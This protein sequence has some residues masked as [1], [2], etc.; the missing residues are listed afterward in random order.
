VTQA[1]GTTPTSATTQEA[2]GRASTDPLDRTTF[3]AYDA[4]G[5]MRHVVDPDRGTTSYTWDDMSRL[6]ALTDASATRRV[7][8]TTGTAE[9]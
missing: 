1:D 3:Y 9:S 8:S 2:G 4:Y 7:S 5:R 6:L